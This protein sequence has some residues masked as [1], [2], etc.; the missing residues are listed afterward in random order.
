MKATYAL[1]PDPAS[2]QRAFSSLRDAASDLGIRTR[3]IVVLSSEPFEE[4]EFA[5]Q[6]TQTSLP[7]LAAIGGIAGGLGGYWL[8][9]WTQH[10]YPIPTGGM[11]IAGLW[12]NGIIIYELT[13]LGAILVTLVTLLT[14][15]R[16]PGWWSKLYDPRISAGKIL[17]GVVNPPEEFRVEIEKRLR[18][19]GSNDVREFVPRGVTMA[20]SQTEGNPS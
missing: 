14:S 6:D 15:A 4:Y 2:A 10:A 20:N 9:T 18:E 16:L 5:H 19:A 7:W 8:T 3:D 1:Y 17:V 13:M 12:T 11:P